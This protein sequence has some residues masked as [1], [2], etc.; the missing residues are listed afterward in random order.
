MILSGGF[1]RLQVGRQKET[2]FCRETDFSEIH[3]LTGGGGGGFETN[4]GKLS[5]AGTRG[6]DGCPVPGRMSV[7]N[8]PPLI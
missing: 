8:K 2:L 5:T 1:R 7:G 6:G 4:T 3:N